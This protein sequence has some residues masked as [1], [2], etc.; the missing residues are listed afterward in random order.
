MR[1]PPP[2]GRWARLLHW[3]QRRRHGAVLEPTALWSH[4]PAAHLAFVALFRALRRRKS[5][6]SPRLQ[7]LAA[8][9][10]SQLTTCAFCI[11]L[12]AAM[13]RDAGLSEAAALA[14]P[15]WRAS[16]AFDATERLVLE[17]AEAMTRCPPDVDDAL[18]ARL[19]ERFSP[20]AIVE[21]TAVI[22]LQNMSARFN[23]ALQ[24]QA[25][26]FCPL[27]PEGAAPPHAR[28]RPPGKPRTQR[29]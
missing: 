19:R 1:L 18:F 8:L 29:T 15:D 17:Y 12:N 2:T 9:R 7:A 25:H 16:S 14:V 13:L 10:V 3:L 24:A 11:D 22:A 21:L 28:T 27:P 5:P 26:G 23:A 20:E 6:V 4:R